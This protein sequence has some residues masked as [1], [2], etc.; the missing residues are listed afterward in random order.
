[1]PYA[2]DGDDRSNQEP[3]DTTEAWRGDVHLP[4][5]AYWPG[6]ATSALNVEQDDRLGAREI[7]WTSGATESNNLAIKGVVEY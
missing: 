5:D 6:E 2:F 3:W 4:D 7:I 1:M